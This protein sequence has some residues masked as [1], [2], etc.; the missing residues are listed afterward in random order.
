MSMPVVFAERFETLHE[1]RASIDSA[2]V[3]DDP[4]GVRGENRVLRG[5]VL[6]ASDTQST[7]HMLHGVF[8]SVTDLSAESRA[9]LN[10]HS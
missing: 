9:Y 7:T 4:L 1:L 6:D 10:R 8:Y 3:L 5:V 2:P